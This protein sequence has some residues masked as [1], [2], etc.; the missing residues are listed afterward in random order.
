M[1][2]RSASAAAFGR[3]IREIRVDRGLSQE[4]VGLRSE[5]ARA[6]YGKVERGQ[7]SPTFETI[8]KVA[9]GLEVPAADIVARAERLLE[10]PQRSGR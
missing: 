1:A 9:S 3:A 4:E 10:D 6:Y 7:A 2:A 8:V 5:V